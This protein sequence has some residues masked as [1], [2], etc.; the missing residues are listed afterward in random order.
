MK[1][2]QGLLLD[3]RL[4]PV[5]AHLGQHVSIRARQLPLPRLNPAATTHPKR[6]IRHLATLLT[7]TTILLRL[8]LRRIADRPVQVLVNTGQGQVR[9]QQQNIQRLHINLGRLANYTQG[10]CTIHPIVF[11]DSTRTLND[12]L[13]AIVQLL[14][15]KLSVQ[16]AQE[17][18][19]LR[20]QGRNIQAILGFIQLLEQAISFL[21]LIVV[22]RFLLLYA[23]R[24]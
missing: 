9:N 10:M 19:G 13:Q 24:L 3:H 15:D 16:H 20:D 5:H 17:Y 18:R 1:A 22:Q 2:E 6:T 14:L 21:K 23:T 7:A 11:T 8:G 4:R 12:F